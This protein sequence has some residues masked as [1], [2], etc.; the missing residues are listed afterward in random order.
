MRPLARPESPIVATFRIAALGSRKNGK[1]SL[2]SDLSWVLAK[3]S[4]FGHVKAGQD[5][6][7]AEIRHTVKYLFS[8]T[9]ASQGVDF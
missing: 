8:T 6:A 4:R 7:R 2:R 9:S 1:L 3:G 5:W